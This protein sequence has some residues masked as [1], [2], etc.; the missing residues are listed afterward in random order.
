MRLWL[1]LKSL[2]RNLF[3]KG[4]VE[5]QLDEE[6]R[7]YAEMLADEKVAAGIP[8][9][10]ARRTTLA[11]FGGIEQVKQSVRDRRTGAG[12]ELLWQDV[13][14]ALRQLRRN[15]A[16]TLTA[17]I[18]LGLGIGATT[19]IFSAVYA[20]LL[21][22]L[23]YPHA[24]RLMYIESKHQHLLPRG[25]A[26]LPG[27]RCRSVQREIL[28]A[29][30]RLYND[31]NQNLTGP[32]RSRSR[33]HRSRRDSKLSSH[34]RRRPAARPPLRAGRRP[35]RGPPVVILSDHLWRNLLPCRSCRSRQVRRAQR[36]APDRH[37]RTATSASAFPI[38]R[39]SRMSIPR[40]ISTATQPSPS[41]KPRSGTFAPSSCCVLASAASRRRPSCRPSIRRAST[42]PFRRTQV[43]LL[44][45]HD[46][47]RRAS[48][49][50]HRRRQSQAALHPSRLR[51]R[52]ALH[53]L[54]QRR[55]PP[56]RPRCLPPPRNRAARRSRCLAPPPRPPVPRRKSRSLFVRGNP[57]P[58]YRL[59]HHSARPPN[60]D[61][62]YVT[63]IITNLA[64]CC[65]FHS[66]N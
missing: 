8:A 22:P 64:N 32:G 5:S 45:I 44:Q 38:S 26:R 11:D 14:Y 18:T 7:A 29:V 52:R 49:A 59:Y 9:Q 28:R 31:W 6:L 47:S 62:R 13:R 48:A 30:R 60:R 42:T 21:R 36:Q 20:L 43:I 41:D 16:F 33:V 35:A 19:A 39:S 63:V 4:K 12:L 50:S 61:T 37:R 58:R 57:R 56:T 1:R 17:V 3:R 55:Q 66:A 40:S 23:P 25:R 27:L 10:E 51:R 2:S 54:C 24:G 46:K 34:A 15:R 65:S 53:R